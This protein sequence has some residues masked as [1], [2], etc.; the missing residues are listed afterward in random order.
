MARTTTCESN[1]QWLFQNRIRWHKW[2]AI[3]RLTGRNNYCWVS[4]NGGNGVHYDVS[5]FIVEK[6]Q[7]SKFLNIPYKNFRIAL[8]DKFTQ[9]SI[10]FKHLVNKHL[11]QSEGVL[12]FRL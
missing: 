3:S 4:Q 1:I 11:T 8:S 5:Q 10:R 12:C 2:N 7:T 6:S 9:F